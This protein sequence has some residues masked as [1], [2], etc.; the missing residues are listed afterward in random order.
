MTS[1]TQHGARDKQDTTGDQLRQIVMRLAPT[2]VPAFT[3]A[4]KQF[5]VAMKY[6]DRAVMRSHLNAAMEAL[7]EAYKDVVGR[8][9]GFP[10]RF[11]EVYGQLLDQLKGSPAENFDEMGNELQS[12][13]SKR[14]E[15]LTDFRDGILRLLQ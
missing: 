13:L 3:Q 4:M 2:E 6:E 9:I 1:K 5:I 10:Q 15:D 12:F 14:L 11:K 8:M 7:Q